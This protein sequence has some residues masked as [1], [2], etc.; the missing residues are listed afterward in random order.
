MELQIQYFENGEKFLQN[1]QSGMY[2]VAF[3]DVYMESKLNG[4]D[5]AHKIR[6]KDEK[7]QIIFATT[8]N[9][10]GVESYEIH[11]FDYLLKPYVYERLHECVTRLMKEMNTVSYFIE[12]K[13]GRIHRKVLLDEV[14]YTD[15]NNHYV[16][17]HTAQEVLRSY[18][19]FD[20]LAE[21]LKPYKQFLNCYRNC[22]VN[23]DHI[24]SLDNKD[25]VLSSGERMP[26]FRKEK[27]ELKQIYADYLFNKMKG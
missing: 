12:L 18:M 4:M 15:Y 25:F 14:I 24:V 19:P 10:F 17:L 1:F 13:V 22:F 8:S 9:E 5:V 7:C 11:A 23:M 21:M 3:L 2:E 20:T 6:E 27:N 16:Q 26:M